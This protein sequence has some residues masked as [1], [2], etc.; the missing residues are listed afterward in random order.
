MQKSLFLVLFVA[1]ISSHC[2]MIVFE[3]PIPSQATMIDKC[4]DELLGQF[5]EDNKDT[6]PHLLQEVLSFE[7]PKPN[8]WLIYGY[9][10]FSSDDLKNFPAYTLK[11]NVLTQHIKV[12]LKENESSNDSIVETPVIWTKTGYQT[13]KHLAF[14]LDFTT[15]TITEYPDNKENEVKTGTFEM[16]K[17]GDTFYLNTSGLITPLDKY[18][19]IV[20]FTPK[21]ER[22]TI[23]MLSQMNKEKEAVINTIMPMTKIDDDAYLAK[24]TDEQLEA[25]IKH[26][27]AG[28]VTVY[29]RIKQ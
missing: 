25:F 12:E 21:D 8:Q 14:G 5:V 20:L 4:P 13:T 26:P 10:Q 23:N 28:E 11:N 1:F 17:K 7:S 27:E 16:R 29:K 19:F 2:T 15:K 3:K 18:W 22:L 9:G 24:P 6:L